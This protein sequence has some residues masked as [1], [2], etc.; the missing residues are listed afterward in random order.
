MVRA[1]R[2]ALPGQGIPGRSVRGKSAGTYD[3]FDQSSEAGR[4]KGIGPRVYWRLRRY[5]S[6]GTDYSPRSAPRILTANL[7]AKVMG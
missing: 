5:Q 4:L 7:T 6:A 3:C 2:K 1:C